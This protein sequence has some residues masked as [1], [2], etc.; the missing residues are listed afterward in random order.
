MG[1]VNNT[2]ELV[3]PAMA[4]SIAMNLSLPTITTYSLLN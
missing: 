4:I 1:S 2:T 3:F